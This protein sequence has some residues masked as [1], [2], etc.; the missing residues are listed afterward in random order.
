MGLIRFLIKE[1]IEFFY[2]ISIEI[3]QDL[4]KSDESSYDIEKDIDPMIKKEQKIAKRSKRII[5][6]IENNFYYLIGDKLSKRKELEDSLPFKKIRGSTVEYLLRR[7]PGFVKKYIHDFIKVFTH[8]SFE[9]ESIDFVINKLFN[10]VNYHFFENLEKIKVIDS[11]SNFIIRSLNIFPTFLDNFCDHS[12]VT[13]NIEHFNIIRAYGY[14]RK[15]CPSLLFL[16]YYKD[17]HIEVNLESWINNEISDLLKKEF[18]NNY[19]KSNKVLQFIYSCPNFI[20]NPD[21]FDLF[22]DAELVPYFIINLDYY[23]SSVQRDIQNKYLNFSKYYYRFK[24][25]TK[26]YFEILY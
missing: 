2:L 20:I 21:H 12:I 4:T 17:F 14:G 19:V 8:V 24:K 22:D 7:Y 10:N 13:D 18:E 23:S 9:D 16:D 3:Y 15:I 11:Q 6:L 26:K 1:I 5:Y 25:I